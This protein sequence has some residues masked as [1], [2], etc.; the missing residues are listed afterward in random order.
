MFEDAIAFNQPVGNWN[1]SH[2]ARMDSMFKNAASFNQTLAGWDISHVEDMSSMFENAA[3]FS[4]SLEKWYPDICQYDIPA[5]GMFN[6]A[7]SYHYPLPY[8]SEPEK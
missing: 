4:Y 5:D 7:A 8:T 2:A 1:T 6:G 3:A